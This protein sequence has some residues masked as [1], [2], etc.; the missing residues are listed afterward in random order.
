MPSM[1]RV[2]GIFSVLTW[3]S[4]LVGATVVMWPIDLPSYQIQYAIVLALALATIVPCIVMLSRNRP[5]RVLLSFLVSIAG[6]LLFGIVG[7]GV[8]VYCVLSVLAPGSFTRP[9]AVEWFYGVNNAIML[10]LPFCWA[11]LWREH[12]HRMEPNT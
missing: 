3:M 12:L 4:V 8:L 1:L 6:G 11:F 9:S 5:F 7:L 2:A 10:A